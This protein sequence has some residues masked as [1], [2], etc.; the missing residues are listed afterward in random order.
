MSRVPATITRTPVPSLLRWVKTP[1]PE[2]PPGPK[3]NMWV[4]LNCVVVSHLTGNLMM[5][6]TI[7]SEM[8]PERTLRSEPSKCRKRGFEYL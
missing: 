7:L 5:Q 1:K 4:A 3:S 6:S 8:E 2:A